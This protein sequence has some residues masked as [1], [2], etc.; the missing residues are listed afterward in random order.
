MKGWLWGGEKPY[1]LF[2]F[3]FFFLHLFFS[4]YI[5]GDAVLALQKSVALLYSFLYCYNTFTCKL[6]VY[7][8]VYEL[9]LLYTLHF[10]FF[11]NLL[12]PRLLRR[13]YIAVIVLR[14]FT[15]VCFY[16]GLY[17]IRNINIL[18][19]RGLIEACLVVLLLS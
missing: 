18:S 19:K 6:H 11:F 3:F 9:V 1:I 4:I 16:C 13:I 17:N 2:F 14:V 5:M 15:G 7:E 10:I 12:T 8:K